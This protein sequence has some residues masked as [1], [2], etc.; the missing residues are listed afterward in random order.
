MQYDVEFNSGAFYTA[1]DVVEMAEIAED[2]GFGCFWKGESNSTDPMVL[3]S[4]IA[5]RTKRIK[6]GSAIYHVFGRSPVTLGIQAATLND[7]SDGRLMLGLGVANKNIAAWHGQKFERPIRMLREYSEIVRAVVTG[8]RVDYSG[9]YFSTSRFKLSWRPEYTSV[10]LLHAGLGPQMTRLA[11]KVADGIIVNLA[12]PPRLREIVQNVRAGAIEAGRDP[13]QL[14]FMAK[15]RVS[16]NKDRELAKSKL[17]QVLTFYNLADHYK[18]MVVEM[19]FGEES[20]RIQEAYKQGGFKAAMAQVTDRMVE[21]LPTIAATSVEE[22]KE[23]LIPYV[24][25]GITR[26]DIPPVPVGDD[27]VEETKQF[28]KLWKP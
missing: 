17:K 24:E 7:L 23:K 6:V 20:A 3:M 27:A 21:G 19:G 14:E 13:S 12:N 16:I 18:D 5:A 11:G 22:V 2:N 28:L 25:A 15:V 8:E 1:K 9:D 26:L 4:A 10:K